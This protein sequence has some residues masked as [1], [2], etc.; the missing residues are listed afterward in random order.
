MPTFL[1]FLALTGGPLDSEYE[2]WQFHAHWGSENS[3]GSE[4]SI[5]GEIYPAE[6]DISTIFVVVILKIILCSS[7][8][9]IGIEANILH[10]TLPPE[11][12]TA[13]VC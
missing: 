9:S 4:H 11:N 6:V 1:S 2:L 12:L 8:S 10:Q 13:S 7:I 3:K 5:D